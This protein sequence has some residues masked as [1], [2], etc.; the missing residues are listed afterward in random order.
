MEFTHPVQRKASSVPGLWQMAER[1]AR[2]WDAIVAQMAALHPGD[3][4]AEQ[5]LLN[6]AALLQSIETN[7]KRCEWTV[8]QSHLIYQ[9]ANRVFGSQQRKINRPA[10]TLRYGGTL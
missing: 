6:S 4:T 8:S 9:T 7:Y 1:Q 2:E 3:P 10:V 5:V